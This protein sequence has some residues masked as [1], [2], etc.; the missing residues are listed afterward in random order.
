MGLGS[1]VQ[2]IR[3]R[4]NHSK[5]SFAKLVGCSPGAIWQIEN[6][7]FVPSLALWKK[8]A[9]AGGLSESLMIRL[10]TIAIVR[11]MVPEEYHEHIQEAFNQL[12]PTGKQNQAEGAEAVPAE[13]DA[14]RVDAN[15]HRKFGPNP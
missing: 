13:R 1:V 11:N 3:I 8:M 6:E 4:R 10:W 5:Y 2:Q 15:P 9:T 7:R 14:P 12:L